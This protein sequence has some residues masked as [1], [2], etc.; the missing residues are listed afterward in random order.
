M[1]NSKTIVALVA[2][3]LSSIAHAAPIVVHDMEDEMNNEDNFRVIRRC[4]ESY[5]NGRRLLGKAAMSA[6]F[7]K[8]LQR[9]AGI[10]P[11][12]NIQDDNEEEV[13]IQTTTLTATS[14]RH[15]DNYL[16]DDQSPVNSRVGMIFLEDN[17]E[18]LFDHGDFSIPIKAGTFVDFDSD[19][20]HNS[21]IRGGQVRALGPFELTTRRSGICPGGSCQTVN[22]CPDDKD[23][24]CCMEE[25]PA[26]V[27]GKPNKHRTCFPKGDCPHGP[28]GSLRLGNPGQN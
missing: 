22:D 14:E 28:G 27:P 10:F 15:T 4:S 1:W 9:T 17:D 5:E 7:V 18:A 20:A 11:L 13:F 2:L 19:V 12:A 26:G 6:A 21:I 8:K 23:Y 25:S 16:D 24:D 3:S